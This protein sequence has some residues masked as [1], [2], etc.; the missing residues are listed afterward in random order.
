VVVSVTLG[1]RVVD[2]LCKSAWHKATQSFI[3]GVYLWVKPFGNEVGFF[4]GGSR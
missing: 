1:D 3:V 4:M 2:N